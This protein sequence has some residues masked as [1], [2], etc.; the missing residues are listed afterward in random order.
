MLGLLAGSVGAPWR[1]RA[2]EAGGLVKPLSDSPL[3]CRGLTLLGCGSW[4]SSV[5]AR[6][7]SC[8]VSYPT[9]RHSGLPGPPLTRAGP[10]R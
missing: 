7:T 2:F 3:I 10:S 9:P 6:A 4:R 8:T 1:L 5:P